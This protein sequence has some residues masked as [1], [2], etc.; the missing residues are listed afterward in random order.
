MIRKPLVGAVLLVVSSSVFA[1]GGPSCGGVF[2][3]AAD[4]T[5]DREWPATPR[6]EE[7]TLEVAGFAAGTGAR[8]V[9]LQFNLDGAIPPGSTI[10]RVTLELPHIVSGPGEITFAVYPVEG[11]WEEWWVTW[12]ARPSGVGGKVTRS[13]EYEGVAAIDVTDLATAWATGTYPSASFELAATRFYEEIILRS[14]ETGEGPRLHIAC[15]PP[16]PQFDAP[17]DGDDAL[18][19]QALDQLRGLSTRPVSLRLDGG[20]LTTAEMG[21]PT[22][23][24]MT[25]D[26][27]ARADWFIDL[28][29]GALRSASPAD[30]LQLSRRSADG[31]H[32]FYRQRHAGVPVFPGELGV[33]LSQDEV[34]GLTGRYTL[35][36]ELDNVPRLGDFLARELAV[37]AAGTGAAATGITTLTYLDLRT[38]KVGDNQVH[39]AWKTTVTGGTTPG[40]YY[41][42]AVSG[43]KLLTL[44]L[45]EDAFVLRLSTGGGADPGGGIWNTCWYPTTADSLWFKESG[46]VTGPP[47]D[48]QGFTAF[49][50]ALAIDN[51]WRG[52]LFRDGHDGNGG[53][54]GYF[55]HVNFPN[56]AHYVSTCNVFEFGENMGVL[57]VMGH[58]FTHAVISNEA[59]LVYMDEPGALNESFADL[60]AYMVDPNDFTLGEL[61]PRG[62]LRTLNNPIA[63]CPAGPL[64]CTVF[65][66]R[67]C[68]PD[69]YLVSF[70]GDG[71]GF[72]KGG[73]GETDDFGWVH[74]NSSIHN[75]VGS[76]I[77]AG[78]A[79][80]GFTITGMGRAKAAKLF[81]DV[82]KNW[83]GPYAQFQDARDQEI[84]AARL[85]PH[86]GPQDSCI[87]RNAWASVGIGVAD[88]DCDGIDDTFDDDSDNDGV[89]DSGDNCI[90]T[91]NPGQQDRDSD[92]DGDACDTDQ[93]GDGRPNATDNC[94]LV[95]NG[96]QSDWDHNGVG[97]A[98]E[99]SDLDSILDAYDNCRAIRN[100]DQ[101]DSDGDALGDP[102][103]ADDDNDGLPDVTDNCPG[104]VN[105]GRDADGD[106]AGDL[107]DN[108]VRTAGVSPRDWDDPDQDGRGN[109]CDQDD[110]G[111]GVPDTT[112]NCPTVYNPAQT[113]FDFNGDGTACDVFETRALYEYPQFWDQGRFIKWNLP[114]TPMEIP[115]SVCPGCTGP[116][117]PHGFTQ[118]LTLQSDVNVN[119]R[120]V[121]RAGMTRASDYTF[122]PAHQLA[123]R[124]AAYGK[125]LFDYGDFL[126]GGTHG[127]IRGNISRVVKPDQEAYTLLLYPQPGT[128][129]TSYH[130]LQMVVHPCADADVDGYYA[131]DATCL[132]LGP[133]D[134]DDNDA[135]IFPGNPETCDGEDNNCDG[136]VD[137]GPPPAS[138]IGLDLSGTLLTWDALPDA[139]TW[140][141]AYGSLGWLTT[142]QGAFGIATAGCL[143]HRTPTPELVASLTPPVGDGYWILVRGYNCAGAGSYDDGVGGSQVQSRDVEMNAA[144]YGCTDCAHSLC[145]SGPA[146]TPACHPCVSYVCSFDPYCCNAFWDS[147]CVNEANSGCSLGC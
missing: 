141:V 2:P 115:L 81:Y 132:T 48:A 114:N 130:G 30:D 105:D 51:F 91:A 35:Q 102:C 61:T 138:A 88:S 25:G 13:V 123:F 44:P 12:Y 93:D 145:V 68:N 108:C 144:P 65:P 135:S 5:I 57:D 101:I 4:A 39:L 137:N 110:D 100:Q 28:F 47:P 16:S 140:D 24:S 127:P 52:T 38:M 103:D 15:S 97:D 73:E 79:H 6:G 20:A 98:C 121:D 26:P 142:T 128:D 10:N 71:C 59:N 45:E 32:L 67:N 122:G 46:V 106:G 7:E 27:Q 56:N 50:N 19:M 64:N 85:N 84:L 62:T 31:L 92:G 112:D 22:P 109:V 55:V 95:A 17:A 70:S 18:Q 90:T 1:Q 131:G 118:I 34:I 23:V 116:F 21:I 63:A 136:V 134:C 69:G 60:F 111:D 29:R 104:I 120:I 14:R 33:H 42:D 83:L 99:D 72:R 89:P 80:N 76:L 49:A 36:I 147:I 54:Q 11:F 37:A 107:C 82:I 53:M 8:S 126:G 77:I 113:N 119:L 66:P 146:L 78:G 3:V 87:V 133:A 41:I 139:A 9:L 58:E 124:P 129:I 125:S 40:T 74:T 94:P 75:K 117:L 143:A 86:L 96:S 43:Q